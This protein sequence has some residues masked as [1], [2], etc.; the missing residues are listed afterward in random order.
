MNVESA[1]DSSFKNWKLVLK[2]FLPSWN[3]FNDFDAVARLE[4]CVMR[5]DGGEAGWRPLYPTNTTR[6]WGRV[7]FNPSGNLELLEKSLIDRVATSLRESDASTK[8]NFARSVDCELLTRIA[9]VR[10]QQL[11]T[12]AADVSFRFRLV[13]ADS[14]AASETLF[15]STAQ[16]LA[17]GQ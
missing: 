8:A 1:N 17:P 3:F 14:M 15:E 6:S 16:P 5:H 11:V 7:I 4:F 13:V 10:V 12:E 9:R 2:L